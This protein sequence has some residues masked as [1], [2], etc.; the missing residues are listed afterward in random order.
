MSL[1]RRHERRWVGWVLAL[2][3]A[4]ACAEEIAHAAEAQ[5]HS[6]VTV[7]EVPTNGLRLP[8]GARERAHHALSIAAETPKHFLRSLGL[9]ATDCATRLRLPSRVK[10]ARES[11]ARVEVQAQVGLTR[12]F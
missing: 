2:C 4:G 12:R 3:S 10:P 6:P 9:D 7:I 5:R 11:G 1:A 8:G